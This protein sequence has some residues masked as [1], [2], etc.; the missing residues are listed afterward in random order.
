MHSQLVPSSFSGEVS[1]TY[2]KT[3]NVD[4]TIFLC[5]ISQPHLCALG[6]TPCN[7]GAEFII[8]HRQRWKQED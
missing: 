3:I 7:C 5:G 4:K 2:T 6:H 8:R 1:L